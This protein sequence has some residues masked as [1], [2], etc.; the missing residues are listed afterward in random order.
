MSSQASLIPSVQPTI[1]D[2]NLA[3]NEL[4]I[5]AVG[6]APDRGLLD[7]I[8]QYGV[9]NPLVVMRDLRGEGYPPFRI[10]DGRRRLKAAHILKLDEVPVRVVMHEEDLSSVLTVNVH[11]T[12]SDNVAADLESIEELLGHAKPDG[13]LYNE[14]DVAEATGLRLATVQKRLRLAGLI[15]PL[16]VSLDEGAIAPGVAEAAA[17]L[18][19]EEQQRLIPK[20]DERGRIGLDDVR[21]IRTATSVQEVAS[22]DF[23]ALTGT[24][25][26]TAITA[27]VIARGALTQ[28]T[29]A[30][31]I[32]AA[33]VDAGLVA[34]ELEARAALGATVSSRLGAARV[35]DVYRPEEEGN[36]YRLIIR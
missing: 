20:L 27:P 6:P 15:E 18:T 13:T 14:R 10:I 33:L 2:K 30:D 26:T 31:A 19:P 25:S 7:S 16:R 32:R 1:I 29:L 3:L 21:E 12:R 35:F 4:P 8:K 9:L 24:P 22:I 11:A 36:F 34:T 17:K 5:S 23:G 28:D